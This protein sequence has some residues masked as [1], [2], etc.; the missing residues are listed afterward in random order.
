MLVGNCKSN[1]MFKKGVCFVFKMVLES[2]TA[3]MTANS[4]LSI[5]LVSLVVAVFINIVNYFIMDKERMKEL[6]D[7][8]KACQIK[9]KD[10]KGD[11]K[12]I[13]EINKQMMECSAEMMKHSFKPMLI[14]F[15]PIIVVFTFIRNVY[16]ATEIAKTWIWWYI[17]SS[18]VFSLILKKV[19]KLP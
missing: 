12:K 1:L 14:T 3:W 10:A 4:K 5:I 18:I 6:K 16:A 2:L 11:V 15:I 9:L 7:I 13:G 19:F 8:Q 17:G